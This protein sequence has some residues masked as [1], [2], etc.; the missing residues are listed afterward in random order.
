MVDSCCA[1]PPMSPNSGRIR[2]SCII[3]AGVFE[4]LEVS[5]EELGLFGSEI[6]AVQVY[7]LHPEV[8][9]VMSGR[10]E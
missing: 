5:D 3:Q 8:A 2:H 7:R 10:V 6:R 4:L 9:L 1:L